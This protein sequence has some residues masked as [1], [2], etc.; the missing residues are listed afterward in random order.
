[1]SNANFKSLNDNNPPPVVD[2]T[3]HNMIKADI[4][5]KAWRVCSEK[6]EF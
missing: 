5:T 1:M 2:G 6:R 3:N 4:F